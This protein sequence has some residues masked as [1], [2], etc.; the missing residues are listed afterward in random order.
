MLIARFLVVGQGSRHEY[1]R[2]VNP[3]RRSGTSVGAAQPNNLTDK[4]PV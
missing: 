2:A 4:N 3:D 1:D